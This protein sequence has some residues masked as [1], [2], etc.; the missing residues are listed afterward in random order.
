L[1]SSKDINGLLQK[2]ETKQPGEP[3]QVARFTN[4]EM[5]T[6]RM[7]QKIRHAQ[8]TMDH[9]GLKGE[10][11]NQVL[12]L[13]KE[14]PDT[15]KLCARCRYETVITALYFYVKFSNTKKRPL[16]DYAIARENGLTE[17]IYGRIV[18]KL[19]KH[20]QKQNSVRHVRYV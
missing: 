9:M 4:S 3:N 16:S 11:C 10:Q 17:E 5:K 8:T 14:F 15:K 6:W 18:T 20:F 12:Y 19:A 1:Q 2:Y 13:I 7:K